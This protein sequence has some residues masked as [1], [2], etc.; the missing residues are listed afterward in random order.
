MQNSYR[1]T[2]RGVCCH[3]LQK[4]ILIQTILDCTHVSL[5]QHINLTKKKKTDVERWSQIYCERIISS[6]TGQLSVA[7]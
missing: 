1:Y 4:N 6:R 3:S 5:Q 7:I 2:K